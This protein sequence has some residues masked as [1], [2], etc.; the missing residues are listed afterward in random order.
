MYFG[1]LLPLTRGPLV[2]F[3]GRKEL[4]EEIPSGDPGKS[5]SVLAVSSLMFQMFLVILKWINSRKIRN[6]EL[7]LREILV[8]EI[9]VNN[10]LNI[11][12]NLTIIG[13]SV[14]GCFYS[15]YH[16]L[17]RKSSG[18]SPDKQTSQTVSSVNGH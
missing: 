10:V 4:L 14:L 3:Y 2:T 1:N 13:I 18:R 17:S 5:L 8:R 11:Y 7:E 12:T 16:F 15:I 9:L 6:Y